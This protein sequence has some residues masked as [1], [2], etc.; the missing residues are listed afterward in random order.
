MKHICPYSNMK[1]C[2]AESLD[3][4]KNCSVKEIFVKIYNDFPTEYI[5]LKHEVINMS[6]VSKIFNS[7]EE[8]TDYVNS[9]GISKEDIQ[10]IVTFTSCG[11]MKY[12]LFY[13]EKECMKVS[14]NKD[15]DKEWMYYQRQVNHVYSERNGN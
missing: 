1:E 4:C 12:Q 6:L 14:V 9:N 10:Q 5:K 3:A 13:W 7:S 8:L 2:S 15:D 11:F